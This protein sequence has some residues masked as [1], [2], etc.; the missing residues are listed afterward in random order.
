MRDR[1]LFLAM[2]ITGLTTAALERRMPPSRP[3]YSA[4]DTLRIEPDESADGRGVPQRADLETGTA[5]VSMADNVDGDGP[6]G[7]VPIP[8]FQADG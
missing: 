8:E 1:M 6:Y 7:M 3:L 2:L 5:P 4:R